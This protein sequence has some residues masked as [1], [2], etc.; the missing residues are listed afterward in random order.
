VQRFTTGFVLTPLIVAALFFMSAPAPAA[1][2]DTAETLYRA[3][4]W[5]D[6]REAFQAALPNLTG[7]LRARA[8]QR[9]GFTYMRT[10]PRSEAP[11]AFRLGAAVTDALPD[12]R[13]FNLIESGRALGLLR[14]FEESVADFEAA[15]A[16][17]GISDEMM[18]DALLS[19]STPLTRLEAHERALEALRKAVALP[20]S[21]AHQITT[22][23]LRIG[24]RL[25]NDQRWEDALS[26]Y[27]QVLDTPGATRSVRTEAQGYIS[28]LETILAGDQA[29]YITPYI[30]H[31]SRTGGTLFWVAQGEF[32]AGTV[33]LTGGGATVTMQ[34]TS[35]PLPRTVCHLHKVVFE[36]LI[37]GTR[38]DYK[39][40]CGTDLREGSFTTAAG[41]DAQGPFTFAVL[42]DTQNAPV[43]HG[44]VANAVARDEPDFVIHVGDLTDLGAS[45]ARWRTELFAPGHPYF[46]R[47]GFVATFGNHDGGVYYPRLFDQLENFHYHFDHGNVLVIVV[48]SYG[49]GR[50]GRGLEA[51]LAW[52]RK[53]LSESDAAW[54]IV[55]LHVPMLTSNPLGD[56]FGEHNF[57]PLFEELG[58]DLVLSGHHPMYRRFVPIGSPGN[59]PTIHV[60]SGGAG[61]VSRPKPGPLVERAAGVIHHSLITVKGNTLELVAREPNGNVIDRFTL[62]KTD[63]RYQPEVMAKAV[64]MPL[65]SQLRSLYVNLLKDGTDTL[66]LDTTAPMEPGKPVT[67]V[68]DTERLPRGVLDRSNLPDGLELVLEPAA[69][70]AWSMDRVV[71]PLHESKLVFT[72]TAP[73]EAAIAGA[74]L[75]P[76]LAIRMTLKQGDRLYEPFTAGVELTSAA[77]AAIEPEGNG[78]PAVWD[79]RFDPEDVGI[80]EGWHRPATPAKGWRKLPITDPWEH[81]TNIEYDGIA[82]YRTATTIQP[83]RAGERLW[84]HFNAIDESCWVYV[85]GKQVGRQLFNTDVDDDAWEKP[86]RFDV[87]DFVKPGQNVIAVRVQ[88]LSGLG[89]IYR[90]A[91]LRRQPINRFADGGGFSDDPFNWRLEAFREGNWHITTP[92]S[93]SSDLVSGLG[94]YVDESALIIHAVGVPLRLTQSWSITVPVGRVSLSLRA[95]AAALSATTAG[96]P[97]LAVRVT[98]GKASH[99]FEFDPSSDWLTLQ[100]PLEIPAAGPK[101]QITVEILTRAAG[102]YELDELTVTV[103]PS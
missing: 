92:G 24:G 40:T 19:I 73:P 48:D 23:W 29:F 71:H 56:S 17:E 45:W 99:M 41:T 52:A 38:Y 11:A 7:D 62:V 93:A 82:W 70:S 33:E 63:G 14:Q 78:L 43:A 85:N 30:V 6:A 103:P 13:A 4:R 88:D 67:F 57:L 35:Q 97:P 15:M 75:R 68:L 32:D 26:A 72:V 3:S 36:S 5:A 47:S 81:L 37:P 50:S 66:V 102:T 59:K 1:D 44:A 84:L 42:G 96:D 22:G 9:I 98:I 60:T 69:G 100:A 49:R 12:T 83:V 91:S 2:Y 101:Q 39:V 87:T 51:Q 61:P 76:N 46:S 80:T 94:R 64:P 53:V 27:Q 86:R 28:E 90:G 20:G 74:R 79:F 8:Y 34:S 16:I 58:V 31:V 95:R 21:R 89:G 18:A 54:K 25:M 55:S 77:A 65:A 10:G